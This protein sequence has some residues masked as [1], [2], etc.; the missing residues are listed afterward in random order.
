MKKTIG[1]SALVVITLVISLFANFDYTASHSFAS[2]NAVG[3]ITASS[4]N[5]REQPNT[6]SRV[7]SSFSRGTIVE[8]H[9][10]TGQ[11]YKIRVNNR[12]GYIHGSYVRIVQQASSGSSIIGS[13]EVTAT[14]LNVRSRASTSGSVIGS[15]ERGRKVDL[16]EQ[17]GKWYKIRINNSWGYIHGDYLKVT[18]SNSGNSGS[19]SNSPAVGEVIGNG[20]VTASRLNVRN[21]AST[22]GSVIGSLERGR[23][24]DLYEKSGQWYKIRINNSWGFVHGDYLK[25]SGSGNSGSGSSGSNSGSGSQTNEVIGSGE[26]T[27]TRLN[28]RNQ[29]STN[30]N[31]IGSLERGSKVDLYEKTG[32]W[33][34][35]RINNSWG[36][37]HGDYLRVTNAAPSD[38]GGSSNQGDSIIGNGEITASNLNVRSSASTS[39]SII[40]SLRRGAKVDLYE[41]SGAWYKIRHNNRWGFVHGDYIKVTNADAS[42]PGSGN[43]NSNINLSGKT[44]FLDPGHGGRDPGAVVNGVYESH[45][46]FDISNKLKTRLENAG[47]KVVMSRTSDTFVSLGNRWRQGNSSGSDIFISLHLNYFSLA[48]ASG[49]EVFFDRTNQGA[50][51]QK[52]ANAIQQQLV[53]Q[54]QFRDRGVKERNLEVIRFSQMPAVL[55]EV[56]FMSNQSDMNKMTNEQ[57][58][59]A[60]A[61]LEAIDQ[62]FK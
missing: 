5:V 1:V 49:T 43:S 28:V 2:S 41:K 33:Y 19:G 16:Y 59:I 60:D 31:V 62:Y 21:Q 38:S 44:I 20:E 6:S 48:S 32:Q 12:W 26:V 15:L 55:V 40:G 57:D 9:E 45:L 50:N 46:V 47:A 51:S 3:E 34:K 52:L 37:V 14:R 25:I 54:L 4:L 11:W 24:V 42:N 61:L 23:K 10:K 36:F 17:S 58:K 39:S 22:S 35:I 53:S 18:S 56:G 29:A 7:I 13:G 8:L 27:A 30:G